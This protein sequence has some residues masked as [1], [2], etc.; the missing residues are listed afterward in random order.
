MLLAAGVYD[1]TGDDQHL[2][3]G[4]D[5][6][7]LDLAPLPSSDRRTLDLRSGVVH[8][9]ET[10]PAG[11][12]LRSLRLASIVHHGVLA[13]R[14]EADWDGFGPGPSRHRGRS[15]NPRRTGT[16]RCGEGGG[17]IAVLVRQSAGVDGPVRTVERVVAYVAE[18]DRRPT[19]DAAGSAEPEHRASSGC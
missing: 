12:P 5:W 6:A 19:P 13:L 3:V 1:G 10:D 17:G 4:P 18:P 16:A 9:V 2:L 8:R 15:A 14:T 7:R 11:A